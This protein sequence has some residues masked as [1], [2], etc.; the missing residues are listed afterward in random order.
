MSTRSILNALIF[1]SLGLGLLGFTDDL[2][3][4]IYDSFEVLVNDADDQHD[5]QEEKNEEDL[6]TQT[7]STIPENYSFHELF[8]EF[9]HIM[10]K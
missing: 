9:W 1:V 2:L 5:D 6:Q 10:G 7:N 3:K 8:F 4:S